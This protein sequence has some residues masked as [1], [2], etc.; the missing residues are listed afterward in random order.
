M[1][2]KRHYLYVI[3]NM[4]NNKTYIGQTINPSARWRDH[5]NAST[6]PKVPIQY[7]I[8]KYGANNFEFIVIA[9]GL[10][11]CACKPGA[12]GQCQIDVNELETLLVK[13]YDSFVS[14][15]NGYNATF[16]GM[17]DPKSEEW[18][19]QM[20]EIREDPV[21]KEKH[22]ETYSK[23]AQKRIIELPDTIP[24]RPSQPSLG[25][26]YGPEV[27][28]M[29]SEIAKSL[30]HRINKPGRRKLSPEQTVVI[31]QDPRPS[32]AVAKDYGVSPVLVQRIRKRG[33]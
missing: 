33:N 22:A 23:A 15:G 9:S 31:L 17:N 2:Q 20:S 18:K 12:P 6:A 27:R 21:W 25:K 11:E 32:R 13:Q 19:K 4:V 5:R 7:A 30:R 1:Q 14:N 28:A 8:K 16:G 24:I 10:L 26:K 3:I 29:R